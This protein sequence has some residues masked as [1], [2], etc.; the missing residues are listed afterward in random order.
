MSGT[1]SQHLV[2]EVI[3][4]SSF[5]GYLGKLFTGLHATY[6]VVGEATF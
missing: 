5:E 3:A 1:Q 4:S 6:I 2:L